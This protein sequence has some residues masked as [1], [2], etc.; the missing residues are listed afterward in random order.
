MCT[1]PPSHF[2][3]PGRMKGSAAVPLLGKVKGSVQSNGGQKSNFVLAFE[4][5]SEGV[6][7]PFF[8]S[9]GLLSVRRSSALGLAD[10]AAWGLHF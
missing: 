1:R 7:C 4:L 8:L 10:P 3:I 2:Q 5:K 6:V 9:L